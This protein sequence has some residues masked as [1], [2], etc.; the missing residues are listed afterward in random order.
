M[1]DGEGQPGAQTLLERRMQSVIGIVSIVVETTYV[2]KIG[3]HDRASGWEQQPP[4]R[5]GGRNPDVFGDQAAH[6]VASG[7]DVSNTQRH[8]PGQL[9]LNVKVVVNHR[10][11]FQ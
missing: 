5:Q 10:W 6:P 11:L 1:V 8:S 9:L 4:V 7:S 3:I 2:L